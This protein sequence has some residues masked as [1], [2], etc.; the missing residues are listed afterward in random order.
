MKV[1]LRSWKAGDLGKLVQLA[2]N[3]NIAK[4]MMDTFP[5]PYS[6]EDGKRFLDV[7]TAVRPV[8][9]FAIEADGELCGGIGIHPQHDIRRMNAELGYWLAEPYWGQGIITEAIRQIVKY[10]FDHFNIDRIFACPFGTN[11]ASQKVLEKTGF[12]LEARLEKTFLK[13]DEAIDELIYAI[14][15]EQLL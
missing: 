9:I 14:R 8:R 10:T 11:I 2:N 15:R 5:H 4:N 13:N 1:K 12:K 7:V 6:V 3:N